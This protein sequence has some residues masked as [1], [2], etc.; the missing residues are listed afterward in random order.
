MKFA[1]VVG[2][3]LFLLSTACTVPVAPAGDEG[4]PSMT[5]S[6]VEQVIQT[7]E[8]TLL[9]IDG[10]EGIGIQTGDD[11]NLVIMVYVRDE[12]VKEKVPSQLD[13]VCG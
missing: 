4:D 6:E 10:V 2:F 9:A 8:A 1:F 12:G 11:G 3:I 13:G 7:H 5:E